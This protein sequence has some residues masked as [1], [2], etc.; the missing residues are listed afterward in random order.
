MGDGQVHRCEVWGLGIATA[1]LCLE[2][3]GWVGG[4][5][6]FLEGSVGSS[7]V[8]MYVCVLLVGWDGVGWGWWEVGK[9]R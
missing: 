7:Y 4:W 3:G 6:G 2:V 9:V 8:C 5:V 1:A